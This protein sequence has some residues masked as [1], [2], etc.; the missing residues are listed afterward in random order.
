[1]FR[2]HTRRQQGWQAGILTRKSMETIRRKP[3]D[4][5]WKKKVAEVLRACGLV[6][7]E[8]TGQVKLSLTSG[9]V[10]SLTKEETVR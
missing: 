3:L 8:F 4:P 10:A 1:V 7:K 9:G 5:E 2:P 6:D